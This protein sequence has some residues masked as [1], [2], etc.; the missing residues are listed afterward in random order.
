[1]NERLKALAPKASRIWR[2]AAEI[3]GLAAIYWATGKLG[4]LLSFEH[5]E[6][7]P[8]W[9]PT[10]IALAALLVL[11]YRVW[12]GIFLGAFLL[13]LSTAD[14]V[15]ISLAL[16][17]GSAI[18]SVFALWL[19]NRY[20]GGRRFFEQPLNVL[21]FTVS[22]GVSSLLFPSIGVTNPDW[23][24]FVIWAGDL[25]SWFVWWLGDM[26]SVLLLTPLLVAWMANPR[27]QWRGARALEFGLL[28]VLL[29]L[30]VKGVFGG[31]SSAAVS[32]Y[33]FPYLCLPFLVW[34]AFRFGQR[35]VTTASL[36]L[37]IIALWGT[38][39]GRGIFTETTL[40]NDLL[41]GQGFMAFNS[42]MVLAVA[43]VV[44]QRREAEHVRVQ[45]LRRLDEAQETERGRI[46]RQ[47]H[48]QLGQELTALKLGLQ[49]IKRQESLP[50]DARERIGQLEGLAD[51]LMRNIHRLAWELHP[52]VLDDFGLEPAL[53][54]YAEEWSQQSG[55]SVEVQS[56]SIAAQRL[57]A[58]I[59]TTLYRVMQEALTNVFRHAQ[60]RRV[61]IL[62]ERRLNH[63]SLIVE[64]DG[65][66][67]DADAVMRATGTKG[68][69]GLL[70][71]KERITLAGG[72]LEVESAPD[73]G[74]TVLVR[75]PLGQEP[76][77]T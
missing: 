39:Q 20:A 71:M 51:D 43:A 69:L 64:D 67:F 18:E 32:G 47:L 27:V 28:L 66:G 13:S 7:A 63:V 40:G 38:L 14:N 30:M 50:A 77:G 68:K 59:E 21:G 36:L 6:N 34:S 16:A 22:A 61:G 4:L 53:R 56:H 55:V 60:A 54:R 70:G 35:E 48:D 58:E 8:V 75:I 11:G 44:A 37:A 41:Q 46:S 45:L 2:P 29:S 72:T 33:L 73:Q 26:F 74:A 19:T 1:M 10:G 31:W 42:V 17:A 49:M 52:A 23:G 62:L 57:P 24:S 76:V 5:P 9:P 15:G 65:Q 12:P 25:Y 3:A